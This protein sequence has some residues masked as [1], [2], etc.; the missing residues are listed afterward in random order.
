MPA[1]IIGLPALL[2][3]AATIGV[4]GAVG[5]KAQKDLKNL[6]KSGVDLTEPQ[7]KMLRALVSPNLAVASEVTKMKDD[8]VSKSAPAITPGGQVFGPDAGEIEKERERIKEISKPPVNEPRPTEPVIETMPAETPPKP[9]IPTAPEI[10][11]EIKEKFPDLS[12]EVKPIIFYNKTKDYQGPILETENLDNK[13][14]EEIAKYAGTRDDIA[15]SSKMPQSHKKKIFFA[16]EKAIQEKYPTELSSEESNIEGDALFYITQSVYDAYTTKDGKVPANVIMAQDEAGIPLAAANIEVF[17]KGKVAFYPKRKVK[18]VKTEPA[19]YIE[20]IGSLNREA[21]EN[22]LNQIEKL[23]DAQGIRYVV[24]EDLTSE[25]AEKAFEKRGFVP[26]KKGF[27]EGQQIK[28][29]DWRGGKTI[30]QKNMVL[31]LGKKN[32]TTETE[33]G[34]EFEKEQGQIPSIKTKSDVPKDLKYLVERSVGPE[35]GEAAVNK[36]YD[37]EIFNEVLEPQQLERIRQLEDAF[38]GDLA[39][40]GDM[41]IPEIFENTFLAQNEDYMADYQAAL[42][43]AAQKTLGKEFKT[44]RLMEKEDALKMLIDGQFPNVKRLQEDAEGNEFYGDVEITGIDGQPTKLKKQAMSFTLS[45]KEA[46]QFRYRPAGG[47][48][49]LKDNDFVLIEYNASPSD[50]VMRGHQGEKELVLR[51]GETVGDK[52]V[53]PNVFKVYDA[54]FGD[55]NIVLSENKDFANAFKVDEKP[56]ETQPQAPAIVGTKAQEGGKVIKDITAGFSIQKDIVPSLL[57]QGKA[58]KPVKDFFEQNKEVVNYKVGDTIGAYGGDVERSL[59]IEANVKSDF[60]LDKFSEVI[61]QGAKEYNQDAVF[62]AESAPIEKSNTVGFS[63]DF[64]S[65]LNIADALEVSKKL[66]ETAKLDGFTFKIKN[67]DTSGASIYLPQTEKDLEMTQKAVNRFKTTDDI[68]LA[69]FLMPDGKMLNFSISGNIRDTEHRR[70]GLVT[71]PGSDGISFGPMYDFMN[72]TG[73]IRLAGN[74]NRLYAEISSKPSAFQIKKIVDEYNKN[75]DQYD[76][77]TIALAMPR[78]EGNVMGTKT[79]LGMEKDEAIDLS[80]MPYRLPN[81]AFI[82]V[83]GKD[84]NANEIYNKFQAADVMGKTFTGI[85]QLNI[86][87]FSNMTA[88]DAARKIANLGNNMSKVIEET[89]IKTLDKPQSKSYNV[90][91]FTKGKDY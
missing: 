54:E 12:G 41:A 39:D 5:Y 26:A 23:A 49:K 27:F 4:G 91:V 61:K 3:L 1:P 14:M 8:L 13:L 20:T 69:G 21:T 85:R 47:R 77:L 46:I 58:A 59:D 36:I 18:K 88:K 60:N 48:D 86:P 55:K 37:D 30:I 28:T 89:G 32:E 62:V 50:I 56:K 68:N 43:T 2:Q 6:S 80:K 40:L 81:E 67:L 34:K 15:Q 11:L 19:I 17:P 66:S 10:D 33:I 9:E 53:T 71:H 57:E 63:L 24:A 72:K 35:K 74:T 38:V 78:P 84:A 29:A 87:E 7:I 51:L 83:N 70:V 22:V 73:A 90:K 25:A 52:R 64:G 45:P 16:L 79:I 76:S 31:D 65:D 44:Y 42:E 82:E 75:R